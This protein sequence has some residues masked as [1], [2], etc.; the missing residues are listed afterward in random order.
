MNMQPIALQTPNPN[1]KVCPA[2]PHHLMELRHCC[3]TDRTTDSIEWLLARA[4]RHR[5]I[6]RGEGLVVFDRADA[7]AVIGY[8]QV[9]RWPRCSEI[10]DLVI[11][12]THRSQ[13]YGTALIQH[14]VGVALRMNA[15]CVEIG[16]ARSNLRAIAL[17]HRLGFVD[18]RT[19]EMTLSNHTES[20]IYMEL[21]YLPTTL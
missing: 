21:A 12:P 15:K 6:G 5:R 16:A 8:G 7:E 4:V 20:V 19:I 3:W 11:A 14:L 13:G 17:Y 2:Q 18:K 10:S 9:T 1:I